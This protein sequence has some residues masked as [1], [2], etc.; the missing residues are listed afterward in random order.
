MASRKISIF[1][2]VDDD[3]RLR[4]RDIEVLR[5]LKDS[6]I[7]ESGLAAGDRVC[8]TALSSVIDGMRV[9]VREDGA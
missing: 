3:E 6:I 9:Q 7:V 5:A 8:T 1:L 4:F 2:V